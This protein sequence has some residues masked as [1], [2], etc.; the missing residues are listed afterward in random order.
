MI[1]RSCC[2]RKVYM[3][4]IISGYRLH[5]CRPKGS[6]AYIF[7]SGIGKCI[8]IYIYVLSCAC[9]YTVTS[10]LWAILA[11]ALQTCSFSIDGSCQCRNVCFRLSHGINHSSVDKVT[12]GTPYKLYHKA[13]TCSMP[14]STN[15]RS[16][17]SNI[18]CYLY[19]SLSLSL[20]LSFS[21]YL[22]IHT[23]VCILHTCV[24]SYCCCM[25]N[26]RH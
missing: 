8:Y 21:L 6:I 13:S 16:S 4:A 18:T 24:C 3:L 7:I 20:S 9:A 2:D 1:G 11:S 17:Y 19:L 22:S 12:K 26:M 5:E 15:P 23:H 10:L 25:T 14:R